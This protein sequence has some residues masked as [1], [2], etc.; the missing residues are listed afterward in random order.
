MELQWQRQQEQE[1]LLAAVP[2]VLA[3]G[4]VIEVAGQHHLDA[5]LEA[6]AGQ[7]VVLTV[8]S[9]CCCL[10]GCGLANSPPRQ[11]L[12]LAMACMSTMRQLPLPR[13]CRC[14]AIDPVHA[15]LVR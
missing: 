11:L 2:S 13:C 5:L 10:I 9:R 12:S 6:A 7:L 14:A 8:Y 15:H 3:Q 4:G 1:E